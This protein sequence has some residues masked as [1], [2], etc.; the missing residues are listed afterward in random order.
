MKKLIIILFSVL[1]FGSCLKEEVPFQY[2][3]SVYVTDDKDNPV[4]KAD[5]KVTL[6]KTGK[7]IPLSS[8][9][10]G[11]YL[12]E[13]IIETGKYQ[14]RADKEGYQYAR[15]DNVIIEEKKITEITLQLKQW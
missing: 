15:N 5:V 10:N 9:A 6:I 8:K 11:Y 12:F 4:E 7:I 14:V 3:I 2:M 13:N 1:L